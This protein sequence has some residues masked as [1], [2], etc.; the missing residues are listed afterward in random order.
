MCCAGSPFTTRI[1]KQTG[2]F[3]RQGRMMG[4]LLE[5]INMPLELKERLIEVGNH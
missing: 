1:A 5:G 4:K 2:K 3:R